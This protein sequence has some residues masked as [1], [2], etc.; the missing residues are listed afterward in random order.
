ML[1]LRLPKTRQ[2]GIMRDQSGFTLIEAIIGIALLS[3]VVVAVLT[4]VS[5]SFKADAVADKQSTAMSL[6]QSQI[7]SLQLQ[8]YQIAPSGGE[9]TYTKIGDIPS[10]YSI[11]SENRAGGLVTNI[12]GVPWTSSAVEIGEA[13][14]GGTA[15]I[16]DDEG[17]QRIKI[18]VKQGNTVVLTIETYKVE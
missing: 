6:A 14:L 7:E 13:V 16:D 15:S 8:N 12:I 2:P 9:V 18:I 3:I 1:H 11:W 10:N 17:L 4:G 5:T